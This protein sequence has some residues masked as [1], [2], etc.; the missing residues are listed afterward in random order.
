[1]KVSIVV[2][3]YN[4][5]DRLPLVEFKNYLTGNKH[6][7]FL[8]VDDGSTD[9]T[10]LKLEELSNEFSRNVSLLI[11]SKNNGKAEA[12]RS[13]ILQ[14][15]QNNDD[16]IGFIDAD[17]ASPLTELDNLLNVIRNNHQKEVVFGS[18]IQL[19]GN[20]IKKN[21]F[22]YL[23]GRVFAACVN[24]IIR[25]PV[26][27]SQC[28]LKVFS[29]QI[30]LQV[31][32]ERFLTRWLFDIEIFARIINLYG[33]EKTIEMSYEQ[34]VSRWIEKGNSKV[35]FR[36]FFIAPFDLLWIRFYYFGRSKK[37]KV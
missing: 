33:R 22:R 3:C 32:N 4:E 27:D 16:Y 25:L 9:D 17:L 15:L 35:G 19:L 23:S 30:C 10:I 5:F 18:R 20:V 36:Y 21:Y 26:Y 6:I 2:P 24:S 13:G 34:P 31:F 14:C 37:S 28:G 11:R 8:F 1:M 12:V 29:R 7:N